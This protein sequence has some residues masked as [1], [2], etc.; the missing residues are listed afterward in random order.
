MYRLLISIALLLL[1]STP[2]LSKTLYVD[3]TRGNDNVSYQ[4]NSAE[5]PWRT[6]GRAAWGSTN[7]SSPNPSEAARAGDTVIIRAGTYSTTGT[8]VRYD[9][10]YNPANSGTASNPIVFQAEGTVILTQTGRGPLIGANGNYGARDYISWKG[11]TIN[12]IDALS[13]SDTGPVVLWSTTGSTIEDCVING[14][15]NGVN[16]DNHN[17]IRLE[18]TTNVVLRN[19]RIFNVLNFGNV[20]HNGAGIMAYFSRGALI[21]NNE[22]YDSG[23]G[24]FVKGG[25]NRDFTIRNNL[26]RNNGKGILTMYTHPDGEHRIHQNIAINNGSGIS[27]ELNSKN[28]SV[29]NNTLVGNGNGLRIG[30]CGDTMSNVRFRN[31]IIAHS[32][33]EGFSAGECGS[34]NPFNIDHNIYHNNPRGWS[35]AGTRYTSIEAWRAALGGKELSSFTSDPRFQ[36][37]STL[38][39]R[40]QSS[41]PAFGAG[42][43]VL[44]LN[45]N[46][47]TSD[48]ITIGAYIT[49]TESIGLLSGTAPA[50][51]PSAPQSLTLR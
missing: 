6:I 49:G 23:A 16:G 38:N 17:G 2:A 1:L 7:R 34:T 11:F 25:D 10:A 30:W 28:V 24:I 13:T 37:I 21:E 19:N 9:P 47:I 3:G 29:V 35:I 20:H 46:S 5:M 41:S 4:D 39:Y 18:N 42:I 15:D 27:I 31:N 8:G 12:E 40:L 32:Q 14:Y 22:I 45:N 33:T 48:A 36:D 51:A 50:S 44:D 26:L 43:D